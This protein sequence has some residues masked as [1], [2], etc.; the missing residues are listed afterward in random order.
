MF[1]NM[2]PVLNTIYLQIHQ[3]IDRVVRYS[4]IDNDDY[5][6]ALQACRR[7]TLIRLSSY[8]TTAN[9]QMQREQMTIYL[10]SKEFFT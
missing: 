5:N 1:P 10:I 6:K 9:K 8:G 2:L 3:F 7:M 4:V